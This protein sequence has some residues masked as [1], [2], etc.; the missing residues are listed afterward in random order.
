LQIVEGLHH[1]LHRRQRS[2]PLI[3]RRFLNLKRIKDKD[4]QNGGNTGIVGKTLESDVVFK[5]EITAEYKEGFHLFT[6]ILYYYAILL[7]YYIL[8]D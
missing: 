4:R 6:I 3:R 5:A 8:M 2:I 7:F 1:K